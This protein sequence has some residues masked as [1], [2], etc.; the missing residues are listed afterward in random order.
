MAK[1][2]GSIWANKSRKSGY[3]QSVGAYGYSKAGDRYF[4]LTAIKTGKSRAYESPVA[5]INDG[6]FIVTKG[7]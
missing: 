7:K 1:A 6:W 4:I 5:A 2:R 3:S